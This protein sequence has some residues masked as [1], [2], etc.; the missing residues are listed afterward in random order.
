MQGSLKNNS[1]DLGTAAQFLKTP[2][3]DLQAGSQ[4]APAASPSPWGQLPRT[5]D[6]FLRTAA[7]PLCSP[8]A[9]AALP[10]LITAPPKPSHAKKESWLLC[11]IPNGSCQYR[12]TLGTLPRRESSHNRKAKDTSAYAHEPEFY[13]LHL[14]LPQ[15]KREPF[16]AVSACHLQPNPPGCS[17]KSCLSVAKPSPAACCMGTQMQPIF[18]NTLL[19]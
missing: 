18:P 7:L 6:E 19:R 2:H 8:P 13:L 10:P 3:A 4:P 9:V 16:T 15:A 11:Y 1:Q 14:I 12:A 17:S 5:G